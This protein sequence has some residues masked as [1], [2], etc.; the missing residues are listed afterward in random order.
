MA[1]TGKDR[2]KYGAGSWEKIENGWRYRR[3]VTVNGKKIM[4]PWFSGLN[5]GDVRVKF[6]D[7]LRN[8]V[9]PTIMHKGTVGEWLQQFMADGI[10]GKGREKPWELTTQKTHES[11][12]KYV[13]ADQKFCELLLKDVDI[14]EM[15]NFIDGIGG[16]KNTKYDVVKLIKQPFM[17]AVERK[18]LA[19][20][21][22][23]NMTALPK[24]K[25]SLIKSH[26]P[27]DEAK[28]YFY[29]TEHANSFWKAAILIALSGAVGPA[30]LLALRQEDVDYKKRAININHNLITFKGQTFLKATKVEDRVR[31]IQLDDEAWLALLAHLATS[32]GHEHI[33][34]D[35]G[36]PMKYN[37]LQKRWNRLRTVIGITG[38]LYRMR[39]TTAS[40][41]A[42]DKDVSLIEIAH[43]MGHANTITVQKHYLDRHD[44]GEVSPMTVAATKR[45]AKYRANRETATKVAVLNNPTNNP[46]IEKQ[47]S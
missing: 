41:G 26:S 14:D 39:H 47:A 17:M 43:T 38:G 25:K 3:P 13:L 2:N 28:L 40:A 4:S 21:P 10:S 29:A 5:T 36:R 19:Q 1:T 8:S 18:K 33:F 27:N 12:F 44:D 6:D 45:W 20:N 46:N 9:N 16:G 34:H 7:W 37:A 30:E 31:E 24:R 32:E 15:Y 22:F 11:L 42:R 23:L 35:Q